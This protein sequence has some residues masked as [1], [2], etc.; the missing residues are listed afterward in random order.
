MI[1]IIGK[2]GAGKTY[3]ANRLNQLGFQ[4]V[5]GYTTRPMREGEINGVDYF[6]IT[7]EEF[8]EHIRN[9]EFVDYKKRNDDYYGILRKSINENSIIV[10]GN[11]KKIEEV[12][13]YNVL[14]LYIDCDLMVRYSRVL[15][16]K[17][18]MKDT[19]DRFHTENF[20]YLYEFTG[21]FINNSLANNNSLEEIINKALNNESAKEYLIKNSDFIKRQVES[22]NFNDVNKLEDRLL[23][24]LKFEEYLLRKLFLE[25]KDLESS[26][27]VKKYYNDI[28]KFLKENNFEYTTLDD[29]L[30]VNIKN[31]KYKLDYKVKSKVK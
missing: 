4:R 22:F 21:L 19:F 7:K 10:S 31:E 1:E 11:I 12:T 25:I 13:G 14:K 28:Y 3:L 29:G 27:A 26:E 20:A 9:N 16:R 23:V 24:L 8:E 18:S 5:V 15:D 17:D 2:N 6:F 30:Y